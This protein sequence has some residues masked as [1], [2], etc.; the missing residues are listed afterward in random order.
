MILKVELTDQSVRLFDDVEKLKFTNSGTYAVSPSL[1]DIDYDT[2]KLVEFIKLQFSLGSRE[3]LRQDR[4]TGE[5]SGACLRPNYDNKPN[6]DCTLEIWSQEVAAYLMFVG[7]CSEAEKFSFKKVSF[8]HK[9]KEYYLYTDRPV[10]VCN[11][12][13]KTIEVIK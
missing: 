3:I 6:H 1:H 4:H 11:D 12:A 9:T 8:V 5:S 13:G 10:Y 2:E 7:S